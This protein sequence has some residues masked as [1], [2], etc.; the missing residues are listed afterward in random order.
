MKMVKGKNLRRNVVLILLGMAVLC[1]MFS[2]P[3]KAAQESEY[4]SVDANV[5]LEVTKDTDIYEN[6]DES[7]MVLGSLK[8]ET[9]VFSTE[10][11]T[12]EWCKISYQ[13]TEGYVR[14]DNLKIYGG[15]ELK[16]EIIK[17]AESDKLI[18]EEIEYEK[19]Q[20][21]EKIIWE[22]VIAVIVVL[23]FVI[24]IVSAIKKN[25]Q[26]KRVDRPIYKNQKH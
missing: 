11:S 9:P 23:M 26:E 4:I 8:A 20:N 25:K 22:S 24:G 13:E 3:V 6:A 19:A 10:K 1:L 2:M 17:N 14:I 16:Q 18:I 5:L 12:D 15:D 21:R 7:S